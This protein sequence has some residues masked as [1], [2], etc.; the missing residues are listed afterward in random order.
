[1]CTCQGHYHTSY[2]IQYWSNPNELLWA[3]QTGCLIDM[4]SLALEYNKLQKTRPVIGTAVILNGLPKLIP[5]VLKKNG[6]WNRKI[7]ERN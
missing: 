1:M 3:C 2:N 4:K 7:T 5:M 6:R